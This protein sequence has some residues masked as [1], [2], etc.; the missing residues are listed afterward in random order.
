MSSKQS[1]P[2]ESVILRSY[3]KVIFFY[4]L[5][6][7]SFVLWII[8]LVNTTEVPWFG[9]FW[10]CMFFFNLFVISFDINTTKFFA[11]ILAV[12]ILVIV[13]IFLVLPNIALSSGWI[14]NANIIMTTEF[15]LTV[16]II[17][18]L[19]ILL[20]FIDT[21]IEY[22]RIER[23]EIYHKKGLLKSAADRFPT[24][25]LKIKKEIPDVFEYFLVGAGSITLIF[26]HENLFHVP[27]IPR[28]SK[29]ANEIDELLSRMR[30][31]IDNL[32]GK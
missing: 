17:I 18:G 19:L 9:F 25:D 15:Y 31:E 1:T 8:E 16:S 30:V 28:I 29:R 21:R 23:N 10:I 22:W 32:D 12:A 11:F 7:L 20:A 3:S 24:K 2:V 27:T 14:T 13:I 6:I 5:M 26:G 4:P